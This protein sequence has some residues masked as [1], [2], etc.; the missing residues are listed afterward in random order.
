MSNSKVRVPEGTAIE[1]AEGG[2][3]SVPDQPILP[4]IEGDGIGPDITRAAMHV[5]D[6]AV[7]TAYGNRRRAAWMEVYLDGGW[8][9]FDPRNN[10]PRIGRVLVARGRDAADVPLT[11]TFG[12]QVMTD[13]RVWTDEI[14]AENPSSNGNT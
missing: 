13:F 10:T 11:L 4:F 9:V 6:T 1:V 3:L 7:R 8:W 5:W 2:R 14:A 12:E